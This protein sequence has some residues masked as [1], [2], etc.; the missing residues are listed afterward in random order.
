MRRAAFTPRR[1][2]LLA[3]LVTLVTTGAAAA[4]IDVSARVDRSEVPLGERLVLTVDVVGAKNVPAPELGN[5]D[6]FQVQYL[7]P[8]TQVSIVNGKM[9]ARVSHV[10][11]LTP[12]RTG[13]FTIGPFRV[14]YDGRSYQTSPITVTVV[15]AGQARGSGSAPA[16]SELWLEVIPRKTD[17]FVGERLPVTIKLYVGRTRVDQVQYPK[18]PGEGFATDQL[19]QPRQTDEIVDGRR[20][21][22]VQFDTAITPLRPGTIELAPTMEMSVLENRRRGGSLG[23][24][25]DDFFGG[26]FADRRPT[27]VEAKPAAVTV[28]PLPDAGRP[29][30]FS[31]AVGQFDFTLE[32]K[33]TELNAG[34]PITLRMRVEGNG[35][36]ATIEAPAVPVDDRFRSYAPLA[37]K[38]QE[39]TRARVFEQV[40]I[41][42]ETGIAELPAVHFSYFDPNTRGYRTITRG[43]IALKVRPAPAGAEP[44]VIGREPAAAPERPP[45]T[46]GRDIVYIKDAPDRFRSRAAA[47]YRRPWFLLMQVVPVLGYVVL[48]WSVRRRE[49]LAADPRLVRFRQ[50]GREAKQALAALGRQSAGARFYDELAAAMNAYLAAKLDLPPGAVDSERVLARLSRNGPSEDLCRQV[51]SLF[52]LIEQARYAPAAGAGTE[53]ESALRLGRELV[54][55]LERQRGLL[56]GLRTLAILLPLLALAATALAGGEAVDPNTTF[57]EGNAAYKAG[58]YD[59]AAHV[60]QR[61]PAAGLEDGALLFNLGNAYVKNGQLGPAILSYER[62]RKLLPRDADVR[63][64]LGYARERAGE[65]APEASLWERVAF[66]LARRA[67]GDELAVLFTVFWFALWLLLGLRLLIP[68]ARIAL[69]RAAWAAAALVVVVSASFVARFMTYDLGRPAVVTAAGK[70]SVRFEPSATGTEHFQVGEGAWVS[71]TELREGWV[72]IRRADGRRG[73]I[74]S[75]ALE[76]I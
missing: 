68:R 38:D 17:V 21:H 56:E 57:F 58:R 52:A 35:N 33:P 19:S 51:Q 40:V 37:A 69:G 9:S 39:E 66:P 25:F 50:A 31:G 7:G 28:H 59:E 63:A 6:G 65:A 61:V 14:D 16:S 5:V 74:P 2:A 1:S 8:S 73:W 32:A 41:P 55:R 76:E 24:A 13:R 20:V 42:K 53:K 70:T 47:L 45:E 3:L 49:R 44:Q 62:A 22:S 27:Q 23:N 71:V 11:A 67:T 48:A 36:L 12:G 18:I 26:A 10:Y 46:L 64:N 34:D 54:R 60:Y 72:Q 29:A 15:P 75:T 4:Q 43:P 30:G